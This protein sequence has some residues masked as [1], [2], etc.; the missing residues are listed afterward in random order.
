MKQV[1][2]YIW[3][4]GFLFI[5]I[6]ISAQR[7]QK[8]KSYFS[9]DSTY[10]VDVFRSIYL[11]K[12]TRYDPANYVQCH[13]ILHKV[14]PKKDSIVWNKELPNESA[15]LTVF[16]SRDGNYVIAVGNY[17]SNDYGDNALVVLDLQGSVV[18]NHILEDISPFPINT[19]NRNRLTLLWNCGVLFHDGHIIEVCFENRY[20]ERAEILYSLER[21]KVIVHQ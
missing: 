11:G 12:A 1:F 2:R 10:R 4:L 20:Q 7:K 13:A 14:F 17:Y 16:I 15:P 5:T 8:P 21:K 6:G 9:V 18:G 19:Y 3:I